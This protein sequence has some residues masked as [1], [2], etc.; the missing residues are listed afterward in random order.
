MNS[1]II[2]VV[3]AGALAWYWIQSQASLPSDAVAVS[4]TP[5]ASGAS[6]AI[7]SQTLTGPGYVYFSKSTGSYYVNSQA[8]TAAQLSA[9]ATLFG[10]AAST[11]PPT[12]TGSGTV[13]NPPAEGPVPVTTPATQS[14]LGS[15]WSQ[16]QA[17]AVNDANLVNGQMSAFHWNAYLPYIMANAPAGYTG[18]SWPP[19][20]QVVFGSLAAASAPMT[21]AAFWA[22]MQP[23]LTQQGL[24]GFRGMGSISAFAIRGRGG[25][26]A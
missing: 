22:V 14:V 19:D 20:P 17:A 26:A 12:N 1:T 21:A 4:G 16:A 9:G 7:G 23:Y 8:P 15:L 3:G 5:L 6:L 24:S 18:P 25:W 10:S 11:T 13:P 2:L